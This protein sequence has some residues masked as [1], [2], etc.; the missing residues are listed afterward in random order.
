[1]IVGGG[2]RLSINIGC[3]LRK[4]RV[5]QKC[6]CVRVC[7]G[8]AR[9]VVCVVR[10]GCFSRLLVRVCGCAFRSGF[11]CGVLA[12]SFVRPFVCL[13][14]CSLIRFVDHGLIRFVRS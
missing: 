7:L 3:L 5:P 9:G 14:V 4:A 2:L 12:V 13:F 11:A 8:F 1:M 10:G 6:A